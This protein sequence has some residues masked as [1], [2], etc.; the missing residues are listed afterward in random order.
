M[1][2][3]SA[4]V[5]SAVTPT[6][7]PTVAFS[8]TASAAA[9]LSVTAP[10]SNSST[11]VTFTVNACVLKLPSALV[12]RTVMLWLVALSASSAPAT[13]TIPLAPLIAKRPP[14]SSSS[15]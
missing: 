9:L 13:V 7:V 2:L 4:S 11:S 10:M 8:L 1:A 14:A 3:A 12:A 15:V 5:A 6:V